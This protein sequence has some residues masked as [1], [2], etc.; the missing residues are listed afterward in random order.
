MNYT[1]RQLSAYLFLAA[2]RRQADL[3]EQ[4]HVNSLAAHADAQ[5]IRSQMRD[6]ES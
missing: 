5:T 2:K 4:L 6:W 3:R 1:P